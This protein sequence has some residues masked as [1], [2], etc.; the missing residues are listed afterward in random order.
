MVRRVASFRVKGLCDLIDEQ[1][2]GDDETNI[3]SEIF[4]LYSVESK[5]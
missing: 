3:P 4:S 2:D 5:N 1:M